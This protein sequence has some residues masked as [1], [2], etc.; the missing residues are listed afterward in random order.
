MANTNKMKKVIYTGNAPKPVGPYSQA[1]ENRGILFVS[2]QIPVNPETGEIIS[3][4]IRE[5][6][7]QVLKN[8]DSI[9]N[10]GGYSK[11]DVVKCTC[12]LKD[13][14]NFRE[15]NAEYA[16]YFDS[17]PP[18]RAAYEVSNLPLGAAIEIEAIAMKS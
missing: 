1:I 16:V 4:N 7:R 11:D 14:D 3:G 12:L 18:A 13:L 6:T 15:M 17:E 9:L 2:G 5:Q 10:A 8:I